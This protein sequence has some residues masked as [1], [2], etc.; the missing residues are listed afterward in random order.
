MEIVGWK[1]TQEYTYTTTRNTIVLRVV[2]VYLRLGYV[3]MINGMQLACES[4]YAVISE[5]NGNMPYGKR[6]FCLL[7]PP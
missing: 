5:R 2:C 3:R 4:D 7:L 1:L 6:R